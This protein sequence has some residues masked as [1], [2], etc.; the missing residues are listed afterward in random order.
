MTDRLKKPGDEVCCYCGS[1]E[2]YYVYQVAVLL[3]EEEDEKPFEWGG[4]GCNFCELCEQS[5]VNVIPRQEFAESQ[6]LEKPWML[7][8][9]DTV[10][11]SDT[12]TSTTWSVY[13]GFHPNGEHLG[14]WKREIPKKGVPKLTDLIQTFGSPDMNPGMFENAEEIINERVIKLAGG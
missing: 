10:F 1:D 4:D 13:E 2:V 9:L 7:K 3:N 12:K 8:H 5:H 11:D 14:T 6:G